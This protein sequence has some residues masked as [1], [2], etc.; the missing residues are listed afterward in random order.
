MPDL[1]KM[2]DQNDL[3]F[4]R[5]MRAKFLKNIFTQKIQTML[6]IILQFEGTFFIKSVACSID[7][8]QL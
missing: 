7:I 4:E 2:F 3:K 1:R 6:A 5:N 8:S